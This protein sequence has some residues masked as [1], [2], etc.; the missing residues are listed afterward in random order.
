MPFDRILE[1]PLVARRSGDGSAADERVRLDLD[2]ELGCDQRLVVDG[3]A[4]ASSAAG[5]GR[6]TIRC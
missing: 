3:T 4:T 5:S 6:S 2:Q 1:A